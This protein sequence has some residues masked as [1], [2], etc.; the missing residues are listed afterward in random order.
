M[1]IKTLLTSV[2]AMLVTVS[3]FAADPTPEQRKTVTS[4]NYVT[5]QLATKQAKIPAANTNS[6]TPGTSVVMYTN[7]AGTIGERQIYSD[8]AAYT[9]NTDSNK[10]VTAGALDYKVNHIPT[11]ATSKL[12]CANQNDGCTLWTI[13]DQTVY[14]NS[15][16]QGD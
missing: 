16:N 12:T 6:G 10:L 8:G 14:G 2:V 9:A 7:E 15:N 3:A 11:M 1:Q 13:D 5:N 4:L